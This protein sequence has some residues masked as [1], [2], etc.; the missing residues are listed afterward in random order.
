MII[1]AS[2]AKPWV[3]TVTG[4]AFPLLDPDPSHVDLHDIA[5]NLARI[6]R[7]NGATSAPWTVA[8]H[9]M[10]VLDLVVEALSE[11]KEVRA[12]LGLAA[13]LHD[14]AEA[15]IGDV[16]TPVKIAMRALAGEL[17]ESPFDIIEYR[18]QGA[19]HKRFGLGNPT[20][21]ELP[22]R[23]HEIIGRADA[24]ALALE[25]AH[26]IPTE[27]RPWCLPAVTMP[28]SWSAA[29]TDEHF[30]TPHTAAANIA[31][32]FENCARLLLVAMQPRAQ[33][34]TPTVRLQPGESIIGAIER[35]RREHP[36]VLF[37]IHA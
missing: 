6:L 16:T 31:A 7:F 29:R 30:A 35:G 12:A 10:L 25:K 28:E 20:Y 21:G 19:V 23:W 33:R 27:A 9:S 5:H 3:Q 24:Q 34:E 14:A 32:E 8:Q 26:F 22:E 2:K 15:Y 36:G 1:N 4:K 11:T 13:L 17:E 18:I 37:V